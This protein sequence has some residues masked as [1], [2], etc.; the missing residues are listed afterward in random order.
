MIARNVNQKIAKGKE[1]RTLKNIG[2]CAEDQQKA[3]HGGV[4]RSQSSG[5]GPSVGQR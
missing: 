2:R 3:N 5:I 1:L 4:D